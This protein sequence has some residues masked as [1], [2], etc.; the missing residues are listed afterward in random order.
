MDRHQAKYKKDRDDGK[1]FP[2]VGGSQ[3]DEEVAGGG[4]TGRPPG[5]GKP[6]ASKKVGPIGTKGAFSGKAYVEHLRASEQL[7]GAISAAL[8]KRFRL[9]E[10]DT[11]QVAV[12]SAL[13]NTIMAIYPKEQ[14]TKATVKESL[15]KLPE[16]P[17]EVADEIDRIAA[18]H[19]VD[20][21]D[22]TLLRQCGCASPE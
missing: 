21:F 7:D 3:K 20:T 17:K 9:K 2:L 5:T 16:I 6:K 10:L 13:A 15:A 8:L 4:T 12:A 19:G 18:E 1:F 14:W 22:A 11:A